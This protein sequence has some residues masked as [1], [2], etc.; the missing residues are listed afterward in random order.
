MLADP[1]AVSAI[2]AIADLTNVH[3]VAPPACLF[4]QSGQGG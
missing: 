4:T 3:N 2:Q 1:A